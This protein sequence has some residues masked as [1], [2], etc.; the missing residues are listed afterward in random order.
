MLKKKLRSK[1]LISDFRYIQDENLNSLRMKK[2]HKKKCK[3]EKRSVS[4]NNIFVEN[5]S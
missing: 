5:N 1:S 4:T 2:V 3:N